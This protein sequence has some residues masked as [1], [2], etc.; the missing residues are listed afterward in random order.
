VAQDRTQ[1]GLGR[2]L[3][4]VEHE[5]RAVWQQAEQVAEE[6]LRE[7]LQVGQMLGDE[8]RQG[9]GPAAGRVGRGAGQVV[10]EGRRIA[11]AG[12]H[13]IPERGQRL[14]FQ[15]GC[16][17]GGLSRTRRPSHPHQRTPAGFIER[18]EQPWPSHR[19]MQPGAAELG[20][21][22]AFGRHGRM[23]QTWAGR[24]LPPGTSACPD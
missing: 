13:L 6:A 9:R 19:L 4:V 24:H 22:S 14:A 2:L 11:I 20:Q 1:P 21:R 16:H 5:D 10:E 7:Q 12:V 18:F 8:H 3:E 15:V 23:Q 17:Q